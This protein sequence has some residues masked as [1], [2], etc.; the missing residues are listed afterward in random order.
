MDAVDWLWAIVTTAL[1]WSAV[2]GAG[3][4]VRRQRLPL[5]RARICLWTYLIIGGVGGTWSVAS[6]I[7]AALVYPGVYPKLRFPESL[8]WFVVVA[9]IWPYLGLWA[10]AGD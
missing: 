3:L 4:G 6:G 10:L 7:H 2:V 1:G 9:V 5:G 8:L